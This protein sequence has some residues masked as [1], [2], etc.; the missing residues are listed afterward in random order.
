MARGAGVFTQEVADDICAR[1]A[2]GETLI[3]ICA[4]GGMPSQQTVNRW[5]LNY[6]KDD[7]LS[8]SFDAFR[9]SYARARIAMGDTYFDQIKTIADDSSRDTIIGEDGPRPN[10]EWIARSRL[11][12]DARRFMAARLRP[13]VYGEKLAISQTVSGNVN[14]N[15]R[16]TQMTDDEL[17]A[18]ISKTLLGLGMHVVSLVDSLT[19]DVEAQEVE[20]KDVLDLVEVNKSM[21]EIDNRPAKH[22]A[23]KQQERKP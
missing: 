12:V 3:E 8:E 18:E 21:G 13:E 11:K 16:Y 6:D 2:A 1:I 17:R 23:A 15:V 10:T 5:L 19:I 9:V 7:A 14:I 4:S 22:K 20:A